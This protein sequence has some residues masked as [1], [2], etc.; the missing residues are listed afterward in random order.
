MLMSEQPICLKSV[1]NLRVDG[2]NQ[3]V[4]YRIATY[5]RGY[6]WTAQQVTQLLEDIRD[7]TRRESPKPEEFYC[8]QPLVLRRNGEHVY[9]VVDGQQRLTTLLL[10]L[11]HFNDRASKRFQL[12]LYTLEYDTRSELSKFLE[13][14]SDEMAKTNIDFFHIHAASKTIELW[15][16][17]HENEVEGIKDAFLNKAKVIWYELSPTDNAVAAFTRLNVGKI[18]LTS[19][20][21]IRALFLKRVSGAS[22]ELLRLR[23]AYEWDLLEKRLQEREFWCFLSNDTGRSGSRI[24]FLFDLVAREGGMQTSTD[25]YAT[26]YY[27]S[28]KLGTPNADREG[29]WLAIKKAFM[30]LEEWFEDRRLYHLVGFL[31][32]KGLQLTDIRKLATDSSKQEFKEKLRAVI[33]GRTMHPAVTGLLLGPELRAQVADQVTGLEYGS[34]SQADTIRSILLLFNLS[35]LLQH[36]ESNIRFQFESFKTADWDIEHVRSIASDRPG[37]RKNQVEWLQHCLGYLRSAAVEPDFQ[38]EIEKF[39]DQP[40]DRASAAATFDPLYEELLTYFQEADEEEPDHGIAN[41]VLLDA[42]TNRSYRNAVFAVKRDRVLSLDRDGVFVPICT[43][44]VFLK[45]YNP[46]ATDIIF[47]RTED[48]ISYRQAIIDTLCGFFEGG[49]IHE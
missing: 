4:R 48:K 17:Q 14:A 42:G 21:L 34:T 25:T 5:Q 31:I 6:R 43:R 7:F 38:A 39:I 30:L 41:L 46:Q 22:S 45:C 2:S 1:Y 35:T 49:W 8:L 3:P 9:E 32:W 16:E 29:E 37:N 26:F 11:R 20:E 27:F 40:P 28:A 13:T 18:P 23:I 19:G 44:N 47:W 15:F 10:I 36:P 12:S 24:D 33:L